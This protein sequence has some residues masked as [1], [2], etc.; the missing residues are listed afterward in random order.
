[1]GENVLKFERQ[2]A[3]YFG[4]KFSV[5]VNS[6]SSAN[7]LIVAALTL[8]KKYNFKEGDEVLVPALGWSTSY[9][10]FSQYGI[11]LRFLDI[12]KS[13]LNIDQEIIEKAITQNTRAILAINILGNPVDF[14][15]I[16]KFVKSTI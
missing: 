14:R 1:M 11:K 13:S 16:K 4:S 8:L 10:P 12:N 9:S 6:G 7:L 2:F 3:N 5:M 15:K